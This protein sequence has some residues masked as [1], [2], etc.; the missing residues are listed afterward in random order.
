MWDLE[1]ICYLG[2]GTSGVVTKVRHR[3]TGVAF[4]V[5][6][7]IYPDCDFDDHEA[8]SL[9]R[10]AGWP[11]VVRCYAVLG[12]PDDD[13]VTYV[14]ELMDAGTLAGVLNKRGGRGIP[15]PA[16]AVAA[17][18]VPRGVRTHTRPRHRAPRREPQQRA[19]ELQRGCQDRR[20]QRVQDLARSPAR[21]A[22]S[23]SPLA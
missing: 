15:E 9:R 4:V 18:A 23:P 13:V 10:S 21:P 11:H 19:R 12:G 2:A 6:T 3:C 7:T 1:E 22:A 14:L 8:K 20:H 17:G 16:L 5:K